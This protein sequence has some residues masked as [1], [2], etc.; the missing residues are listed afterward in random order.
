VTVGAGGIH[1][2][3]AKATRLDAIRVAHAMADGIDVQGGADVIVT[4]SEVD[5]ASDVGVRATN[6]SALG[7]DASVV[8]HGAGPGLV[9]VC[10]GGCSCATMSGATVTRSIVRDDAHVGVFLSGVTATLTDV[11]IDST[12]V[13]GLE[14]NSGGGLVATACAD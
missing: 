9:A 13:R 1:I 14:A 6:A 8:V 12:R 4:R 11:A 3:G 7:W 2:D 5:A 10:T